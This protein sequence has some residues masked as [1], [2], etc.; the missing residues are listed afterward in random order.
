MAIHLHFVRK[1]VQGFG[2]A[3]AFPKKLRDAII[4]IFIE[5]HED[6][7]DVLDEWQFFMLGDDVAA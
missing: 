2:D 5:I 3:F 7:F 4:V 1:M 6:D